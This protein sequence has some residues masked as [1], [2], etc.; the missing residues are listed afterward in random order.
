MTVR[1]YIG[2]RYV[3]LF[4]GAWDA[5]TDYEPLCIVTDAGCSYTSMQAVPAGTP[6]SNTS[7]W[8][9]S[10]NYNA[11]IEQYR[12]EV[13]TYADDIQRNADDIAALQ[14][15]IGDSSAG[16]VKDVA[17]NSNDIAAL[18]ATVGD[19][20][21]GLVK[22]VSDNTASIAGIVNM[23]LP[24]L[25]SNLENSISTLST[26]TIQ[27][28]SRAA[29]ISAQSGD[30][31]TAVIDD[32]NKPFKT[33]DAAI[34]AISLE[35]TNYRF[36]FLD[37]GTYELHAQIISGG[38]WHFLTQ[39]STDIAINVVNNSG[40]IYF[41]DAHVNFYGHIDSN[42]HFNT[43]NSIM[44]FEGSTL[45]ATYAMFTCSY[46]YLI[47]GSHNFRQVTL[48][49]YLSAEFTCS[50]YTNTTF[51]NT[52]A[53]SACRFVGCNARFYTGNKIGVN[54][55]AGGINAIVAFSSM[56]TFSAAISSTVAQLAYNSIADMHS[57][58]AFISDSTYNALTALGQNAP[59]FT[60]MSIRINKNG[61]IAV[62]S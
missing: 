45:W 15:T 38:V 17:D 53:Q 20:S 36:M 11:Q 23:A 25:E 55:N 46:M 40:S 30:D 42:F 27:E 9:L 10:G 58:I 54:A 33:L 61:V 13:R 26:A 31:A 43:G 19:S 4:M 21:A 5:A 49:G 56:I 59:I 3:P 8:A 39:A 22:D 44:E 60:S 52:A 29:Y 47:Q 12:S 41:Y 48:N 34:N 16:L 35:S 62:E 14:T 51:N 50:Q 2:A 32:I 6:V 24:T 57:S 37:G 7:Y 1:E 28:N 18:Q